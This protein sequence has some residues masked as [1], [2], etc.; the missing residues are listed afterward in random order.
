MKR[1]IGNLIALVSALAVIMTAAVPAS[2]QQP[3]QARPEAPRRMQMPGMGRITHEND[4]FQARMIL[5]GVQVIDLKG[6]GMGGAH[7]YLVEGKDSALLIDTGFGKGDLGGFVKSVTQL[8]LTVVNTHGHPDHAG[9]SYAG[10]NRDFEKVYVHPADFPMIRH[11]D[12]LVPVEEGHVFDLGGRKLEVIAIPGHTPGH[13]ALLDSDA[14]II[15]T[16]DEVTITGTWLQFPNCPPVE[17]YLES[18]LKLKKRA[19]EFECCF[20]GHGQTPVDTRLLSEIIQNTRNILDGKVPEE[21]NTGPGG[22]ALVAVYDRSRI[23]YKK[24][25][26]RAGQK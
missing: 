11:K 23:L 26:L 5:A 2:G 3:G 8:P 7:S 15:F 9:D 19:A 25:N 12:N 13:I 24:E 1:S 16:G 17:V 20:G 10:G 4:E 22:E 6:A 14:K 18:M 21:K